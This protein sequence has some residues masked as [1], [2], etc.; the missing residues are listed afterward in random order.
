MKRRHRLDAQS[1]TVNRERT[2]RIGRR[3]RVDVIHVVVNDGD[4]TRIQL[5]VADV[6]HFALIVD[7]G[8]VEGGH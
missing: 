5:V 3:D 6:V 4:V 2:A 8:G 1:R 7:T